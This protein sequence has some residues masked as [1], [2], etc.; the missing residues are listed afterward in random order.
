MYDL[1][2]PVF[3]EYR[4]RAR[5]SLHRTISHTFSASRPGSPRLDV[6]FSDTPAESVTLVNPADP[7]P[8]GDTLNILAK[9]LFGS[10]LQEAEVMPWNDLVSQ[11]W[12]SITREGLA[13]ELR[14]SL[15][16]KFRP[17]E[18]RAF[19][20]AP[21]LNPEFKSALKGNSIVK[22]DEFQAKDQ[23][24][25]GIALSAFGEAISE[26][27]K[28]E[29][30]QQS[31]GPEARL[32]VASV[33]DG[34]KI[35]GDLFY[36]LSLSRRAQIKPS[37]N[38]LAKNTAEAIPADDLL[39]GSSFGEELKKATSIEK[40]SKDIA[41]TPLVISRNTH[42]PIK[43]PTRVVP[44]K[45]GNSRVPVSSR[46]N[47]ATTR[48]GTSRYSNDSRRPSHRPRSHSRRR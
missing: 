35:L 12:Q 19:L 43:Q 26:F 45:P 27:L 8:T 2:G 5:H 13:T 37:L 25:V 40:S 47:A 10:D 28:P 23:D 16:K 22:R 38:L 11:T 1:T 46:R 30:S 6:A 33:N 41:R 34:A 21:R 14:E 32:A 44:P 42:Q 24:Q 7:C 29:V 15:L 9:E 36:R 3:A 18:A 20:K 48:T 4:R 39:F 17:I 31:L